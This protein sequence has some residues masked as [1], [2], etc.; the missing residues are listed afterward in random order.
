[1]RKEAWS[2]LLDVY[3]W[4]SDVKQRKAIRDDKTR[5]YE[6]LKARWSN[7]AALQKT[8]RFIEESHRVGEP[9]VFLSSHQRS[10][11]ADTPSGAEIDCRRTDRTHA[12]F[13]ANDEG[14][15]P[16][17]SPHPPSNAHVKQTQEILLTYVF[18]EPDRDYV[19]GMSDLLSPIYVVCDGDQVLAFWC[20][21]RVMERMKKNFLRDQS[22]MKHQLSLLQGLIRTM[23]VQLYKHLG[24]WR[25]RALS[26]FREHFDLTHFDRGMRRAQLVFLL[27][28]DL[29]LVQARA[30]V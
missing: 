8:E 23:D 22:G 6:S 25:R 3:P 21:T 2:F 10:N 15:D 12:M 9:R 14:I 19:Q 4:N 7:D 26:A 30:H 1:M 17:E 16:T 20:F 18:A 11:R 5:M 27:S 13:S 28:M 24:A 29:V